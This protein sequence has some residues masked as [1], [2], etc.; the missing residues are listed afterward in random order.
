MDQPYVYIM[1]NAARGTIYVG[2]TSDLIR[3]AY[4][5]RELLCEGFTRKYKC[6]ILVWFE[7]HSTMESAILREKQL[8]AGNRATKLKIIE[9]M[10]PSWNDLFN[11][12]IA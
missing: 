5:H 12:I 8:K 6:T 11:L 7:Q 10:N 9:A 3:R 4:A 2:A 1:A